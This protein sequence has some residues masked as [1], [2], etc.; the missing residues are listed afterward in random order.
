MKIEHLLDLFQSR[1]VPNADQLPYASLE[2]VTFAWDAEVLNTVMDAIRK[3][4][5]G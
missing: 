3:I 4:R 5:H 2:N 1:P